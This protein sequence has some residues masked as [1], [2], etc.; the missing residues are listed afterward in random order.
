MDSKSS[1]FTNITLISL[2]Q[3]NNIHS[4]KFLALSNVLF[5]AEISKTLHINSLIFVINRTI[6]RKNEV[7]QKKPQ[8]TLLI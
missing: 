3:L 6:D 7:M 4:Y 2:I 1:F 8:M 5:N